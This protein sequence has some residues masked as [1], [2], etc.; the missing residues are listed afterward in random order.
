MLALCSFIFNINIIYKSTSR[1]IELKIEQILK[2]ISVWP[3][4]KIFNLFLII[5][6]NY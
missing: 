2:F 4:I 3:N 5:H 6:L 1:L